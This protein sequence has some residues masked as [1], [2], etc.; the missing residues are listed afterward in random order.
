MFD[1]KKAVD[2]FCNLQTTKTKEEAFLKGALFGFGAHQACPT[3]IWE[4][5]KKDPGFVDIEREM[6]EMFEEIHKKDIEEA[7]KLLVEFQKKD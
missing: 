2:F 6:R 7:R 5:M 4:L 1:L 3:P